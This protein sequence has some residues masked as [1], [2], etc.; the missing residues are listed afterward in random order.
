MSTELDKIV[1]LMEEMGISDEIVTPVGEQV[2]DISLLKNL[3]KELI[4]SESRCRENMIYRLAMTLYHSDRY[5]DE[6]IVR[7]I[8]DSVE[9]YY[10][11][12]SSPS[13]KEGEYSVIWK[14]I[15]GIKDRKFRTQ[16]VKT[17][18]C[19]LLAT[20]LYYSQL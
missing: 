3:A 7:V 20:Y 13:F 1:K 5:W 12:Y 18:I 14:M 19:F 16:F 8:D 17:L 9:I 4:L 10:K 15:N 6:H 2:E 11:I